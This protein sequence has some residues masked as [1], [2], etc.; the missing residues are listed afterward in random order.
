MRRN[1]HLSFCYDF[2]GSPW[3]ILGAYVLLGLIVFTINCYFPFTLS[4]SPVIVDLSITIQS[5]YYKFISS[6][7]FLLVNSHQLVRHI[8]SN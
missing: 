1:N 7:I 6:F 3:M 5:F 4:L 8:G 2:M